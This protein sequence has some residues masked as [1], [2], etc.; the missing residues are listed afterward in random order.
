MAG[1]IVRW[2]A[3][4]PVLALALLAAA[5]GWAQGSALEAGGIA[6]GEVGS[7]DSPSLLTRRRS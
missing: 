1:S 6:E 5:P 4:A 2:G 7:A 3:A